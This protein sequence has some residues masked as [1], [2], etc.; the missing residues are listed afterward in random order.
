MNSRHEL[1]PHPCS[2][3]ADRNFFNLTPNQLYRAAFSLSIR[4]FTQ[5]Q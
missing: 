5:S 3:I 4:A 1:D 2:A